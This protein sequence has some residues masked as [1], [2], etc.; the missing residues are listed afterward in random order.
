MS[1]FAEAKG[2]QKEAHLPRMGLQESKILRIFVHKDLSYR[3]T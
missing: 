2:T 1:T 3:Q